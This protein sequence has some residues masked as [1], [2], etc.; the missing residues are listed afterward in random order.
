M[1]ESDPEGASVI[2]RA[3]GTWPRKIAAGVAA[4]AVVVGALYA[5]GV[6]GVPAV[7]VVDEGD[8]GEVTDERTEIVTTVWVDNPNPVGVSLGES[9][10]ADYDISLNG[11][12]VAEGSK[13]D[14]AVPV[15]NSTTE[16]RTDL[17]NDQLA[18][19]WVEFVRDNETVRLDAN[20]TLNVQAG[21]SVSHDFR[22]SRTML[23]DS[24]P[25]IDALSGA[26]N[27]TS[28]T[29]T[30]SVGTDELD[31]SLDTDLGGLVGD[32]SVTVGYEVERGWATWGNVTEAETTVRLHTRVHNPGDVPV[33]AD[34]DGLGVAVDMNDVRTFE[35]ESDEFS[36]RG[37]DRDAVIAPG[38]TRTV[39]FAVTMDNGKVDDW[40]TSHV[41]VD[42]GPGVEATAVSAN[43]QLVFDV[44]ATD[45]TFRLPTDG[46]VAYDCTFRTAILVDDGTTGT[47]C[48]EFGPDSATDDSLVS[49]G[50]ALPE[51]SVVAPGV[52][53][54][55]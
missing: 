41:A 27:E 1:A 51:A 46:P 25:V 7:G 53:T 29:Y 42:G 17:L 18:P 8:W 6:V 38:E 30:R 10:T 33:P 48:G 40:F 37:V 4:L 5:L 31:D 50:T 16:L 14:I 39:T 3:L 19:W 15:G 49:N 43:F 22:E 45:E 2:E 34:P 32:E 44:P 47:T 52:A 21:A 24:T 9:V 11:V 26:V 12:R 13:S 35:A 36:L 20:A 55:G 23:N 28:G 54:T